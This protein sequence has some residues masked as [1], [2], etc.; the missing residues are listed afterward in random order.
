MDHLSTDDA[1]AAEVPARLAGERADRVAAQLFA[2]H[3]RSLL[4]GWLRCGALTVD[5]EVV[6]PNRRLRAG[7]VLRLCAAPAP[8]EED[9]TTPQEVTFRL[10]HEDEDLLVVDKPAGV[11]VHPGAGKPDGT[12]ANGLLSHRPG[13]A[14]LPRAGIVHRLDQHTSGLLVVAASRAAHQ[15]LTDALFRHQVARRYLGVAENVLTGGRT[16]D[17][18][19]GRDPR[20]RTRQQVR[21]DG[22]AARTHVRVRERFRAHTYFG[23]ALETGR[24]HQ[25]RVHMA[26]IGHPLVGDGRYRARGRLPRGCHPQVALCLRGFRRQALHA[27]ELAFA[28]PLSRE[29]CRFTAPLPRDMAELLAALRLDLAAHADAS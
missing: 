5:G 4:A 11:V 24:T 7:E 10:V 17:A 25:I 14:D 27:A 19:L 13:L 15:G 2:M 12:L 6:R 20:Q 23:A 8:A 1:M 3:S 22:R 29:P 26:S 16:I 28:H 9:W 18:P 21:S